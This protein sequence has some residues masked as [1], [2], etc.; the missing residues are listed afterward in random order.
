M[1]NL[2]EKLR[3]AL[4]KPQPDPGY[5]GEEG[6]FDPWEDVIQ[7]VYGSY[8]SWCDVLMIAALK[9]VRDRTTFEFMEDHPFIAEFLLYM[10]A[11]HGYTEYGTSPRGGWPDPAV[12]D[13]W[14]ELIDKWEAYS[15]IAWAPTDR[16]HTTSG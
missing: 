11:G 15:A 7:G 10:L 14:Q 4:D 13:V 6:R 5:V 3:L 9:A 1:I 12:E 16:D 2:R 8:A